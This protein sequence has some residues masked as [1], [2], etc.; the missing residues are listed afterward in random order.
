MFGVINQFQ[1]LKKEIYILFIGKL[2]T[3]MGSFVWPMLT[4]FLTTKLGYSDQLATL[5]LATATILSLPASIVGGRLTDKIGRKKI[6]VIF[7]IVTVICYIVAAYTPYSFYTVLIIFIAGLFQTAE[8][9]AYDALVADF[10]TSKTRDKSYSLSYL[11]YNLGFILGASFSGILFKDHFSLALLINGFAILTSTILIFFFIFEKN[12]FKA[13]EESEHLIINSIYEKPVDDNLS[14]FKALK[15]RGV[16][17]LTV[18]AS[19][20]GS[21]VYGI[22]GLVLPLQL[23]SLMGEN[24]A[25]IYGYLASFNGLTVIIFTPILALLL[26]KIHDIPKLTVTLVL[27]IISMLLFGF[28]P[29]TAILFIGEFIY[30]LGE[31]SSAISRS[32]YFS[33]RIP[34]SHRGRVYGMMGVFMTAFS[35][36]SQFAAGI[37]LGATNNNYKIVWSIFMAIGLLSVVLYFFIYKFD[38]KTFPDLYDT[39]N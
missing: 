33:R 24:G 18:L 23:K 39:R 10:S 32:P 13:Q 29:G 34:S 21:I 8:G 19:G 22:V 38:K 35:S 15:G 11:G 2:V 14:A 26:R 7:D 20:L 30:T 36:L 28:I 27:Y 37:I 3:A 16:L 25:V 9:P 31:V 4:F 17:Y 1:G 12:S 6:I 5:I